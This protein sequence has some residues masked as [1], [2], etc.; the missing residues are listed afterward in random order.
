MGTRCYNESV[1]V[2]G[3]PAGLGFLLP[4]GGLGMYLKSLRLRFLY[5]ERTK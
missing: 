2:R 5:V 4:P 3:Q 1:D